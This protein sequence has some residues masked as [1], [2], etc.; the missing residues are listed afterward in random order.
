[1]MSIIA[2]RAL[3]WT[4]EYVFFCSRIKKKGEGQREEKMSH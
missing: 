2:D 1:M 4:P 3:K